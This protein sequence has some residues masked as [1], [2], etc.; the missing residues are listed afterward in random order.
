[1][2]EMNIE[3]E[4][5]DQPLTPE[6]EKKLLADVNNIKKRLKWNNAKMAEFMQ[7]SVAGNKE[8]WTD[9]NDD[10]KKLFHRSLVSYAKDHTK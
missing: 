7:F 4:E 8:K 10:D 6:T 5:T 2:E 9:L 1:M 3:Y